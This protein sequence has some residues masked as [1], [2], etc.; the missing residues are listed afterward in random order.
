MIKHPVPRE[1]LTQIGDITV[2]FALLEQT[3]QFMIWSLV[4]E[5][6]RIGQII[7][8]EMSFRNLRALLISLYIERNGKDSGYEQLRALMIRAGQIEEVR[9]QITHSIW[10][11]G[12]SPLS[13]IRIKTTAKEKYG[14]QTK[15]EQYTEG[16]LKE[17]SDNIK[18]LVTEIQNFQIEL[19]EQNKVYN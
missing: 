3:I 2:S 1:L 14:F 19:F 5:H 12:H 4:N 8:S 6:Q 9:N 11:A 15:Y 7:T 17:I 13:I 16:S 10:G 18:T